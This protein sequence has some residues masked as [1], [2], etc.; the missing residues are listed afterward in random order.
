MLMF[1]RYV[2][3]LENGIYE[4]LLP[5]HQTYYRKCI[6]LANEYLMKPENKELL[7]WLRRTGKNHVGLQGTTDYAYSG[8]LYQL[9]EYSGILSDESNAET[10]SPEGIC[11]GLE[12]AGRFHYD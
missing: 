6:I 5:E 3:G 11:R 8:L 7:K 10:I 12:I 4:F 1:P 2:Q 9:F